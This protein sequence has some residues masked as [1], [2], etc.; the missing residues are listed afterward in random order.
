MMHV[1]IKPVT[2]MRIVNWSALDRWPNNDQVHS[3]MFWLLKIHGV[4]VLGDGHVA[5]LVSVARES[6]EEE[7]RKE[8]DAIAAGAIMEW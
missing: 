6:A 2:V 4:A 1:P 7:L 3:L 5:N 8:Q